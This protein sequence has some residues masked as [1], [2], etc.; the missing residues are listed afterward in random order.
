[1]KQTILQIRLVYIQATHQRRITKT[2]DILF[3]KPINHLPRQSGKKSLMR[4]DWLENSISRKIKVIWE[5]TSKL[6][7]ELLLIS[8][9]GRGH[10]MTLAVG[11]FTPFFHEKEEAPLWHRKQPIFWNVVINISRKLRT[12]L[13]VVLGHNVHFQHFQLGLHFGYKQK[14]ITNFFLPIYNLFYD[15]VDFIMECPIY[16]F[17]VFRNDDGNW[18]RIASA[19]PQII[20]IVS[21]LYEVK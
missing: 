15:F 18:L 17:W 21:S 6:Y 5:I 20:N 4:E 12:D 11:N 19:L 16:R 7:R 9:I 1:M 13:Q 10:I 8:H 3:L 2:Q 14:W